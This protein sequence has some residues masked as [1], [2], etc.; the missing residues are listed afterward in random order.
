MRDLGDAGPVDLVPVRAG[1][2]GWS[3]Y[4]L[5]QVEPFYQRG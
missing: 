1:E 5:E 4:F 2:E 3:W